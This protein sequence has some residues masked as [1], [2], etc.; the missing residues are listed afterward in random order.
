M[1][2][3]VQLAFNI[4]SSKAHLT[5]RSFVPRQ[6]GKSLVPMLSPAATS[7]SVRPVDRLDFSHVPVS[8]EGS[9]ALMLLT[10]YT[11]VCITGTI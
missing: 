6:Q 1:F 3:T 7:Q 8:R 9:T 5:V 2:P 10:Y 11:S 4:F